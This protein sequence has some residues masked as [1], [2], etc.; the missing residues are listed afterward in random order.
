MASPFDDS[1]LKVCQGGF[2]NGG[3]TIDHPLN[4]KSNNNNNDNGGK[5]IFQV[6]TC[7]PT[8]GY[9]WPSFRDRLYESE[10]LLFTWVL[11]IY[12]YLLGYKSFVDLQ[13]L[14]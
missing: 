1:Y 4:I 9:L 10:S 14:N 11:Y 3:S 6:F 7:A 8:T 5:I 13:S 12:I 2:N